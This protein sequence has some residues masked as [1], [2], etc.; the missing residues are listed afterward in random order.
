MTN[1]PMLIVELLPCPFCGGN[2]LRQYAYYPGMDVY[3][4][5]QCYCLGSA[6]GRTPEEAVESWNNRKE[7]HE[8]AN[9]LA[10]EAVITDE[11]IIEAMRPSISSAD[12]GYVADTAPEN[13]VAAGRDLLKA[14]KSNGPKP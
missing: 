8:E 4:R 3:Y 14:I 13:I 10:L 9:I 2:D 7:S 5:V 11:Q 12:G 1:K 6:H